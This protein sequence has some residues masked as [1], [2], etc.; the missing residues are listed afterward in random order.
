MRQSPAGPVVT[1]A[2]RLPLR[3]PPVDASATADVVAPPPR[4]GTFSFGAFGD[5]RGRADFGAVDFS[6][7]APP[8][9]AL[10]RRSFSISST[11]T[12]TPPMSARFVVVIPRAFRYSRTHRRRAARCSPS[13]DDDPRAP[14]GRLCAGINLSGR[15]RSVSPHS[16]AREH[17]QRPARLTPWRAQSPRDWAQIHRRASRQGRRRG[18]SAD[19]RSAA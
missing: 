8:V 16:S 6:A 7:L 18:G 5:L 12:T 2:V 11:S 14:I 10:S 4:L 1:G 19:R 9:D 15:Q 3:R 17:A 13:C